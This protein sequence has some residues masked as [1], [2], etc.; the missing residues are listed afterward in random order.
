MPWQVVAGSP[1]ECSGLQE[2]DRIIAVNHASV[3]QCR[4]AELAAR[5]RAVEDEVSLLVIDRD[6]ERLCADRG[7]SYTDPG[8]HV[9]H[10]MCPHLPPKSPGPTHLCIVL[11]RL[12]I[13]GGGGSSSSSR[14]SASSSNTF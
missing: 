12:Q 10:I 14:R 8:H 13:S 7:V 6:A 9:K 1:A 11:L 3:E 5:I 2:G 4:H